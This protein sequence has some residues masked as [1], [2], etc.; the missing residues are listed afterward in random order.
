MN[1]ILGFADILREELLILGANDL[2][3]FAETIHTSGKRLLNLLNDILDISRIEANK[4]ELDIAP[5][6]LDETILKVV[7]LLTPLSLRKHISLEILERT[8]A[9]VLADENRLFQVLNNIIG[10]AIKFTAKGGVTIASHVENA[11][12]ERRVVVAVHDTGSGIEAEFLPRIFE[13]FM[14]E[15]SG[16]SRS[17]EGSGLGLAISNRLVHLMAGSIAIDSAKGVGTK[18]TVTLPAAPEENGQFIKTTSHT[19]AKELLDTLRLVKPVVLIVEDDETSRRYFNR[20]LLEFTELYQAPNGPDAME[21]LSELIAAGKIPDVILVDIGLPLPMNG[22][23]LRIEMLTRFPELAATPIIA[24]TAYA[25]KD[26]QEALR[27]KGFNGLLT[28]PVSKNELLQ[29]IIH[30]SSK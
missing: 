18:V 5:C 25:M 21:K 24:Q 13:P 19:I 9:V 7:T 27:Q 28:K 2:Y 1:G 29:M 26:E 23:Q 15:S 8:N 6:H 14:Q 4:L 17:H 30:Y 16:F 3:R 10:N 22:I 11:G 12:S 20:T